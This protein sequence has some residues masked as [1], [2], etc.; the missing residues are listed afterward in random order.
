MLKSS[1]YTES[2][3][4]KAC[5]AAQAQKKPNILKIMH[6]YGV[7]IAILD[8]YIKKGRVDSLI[9]LGNQLIKHLRGIRRKP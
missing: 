8:D 7:L 1:K 3:L 5:E 9:Q 4:C 6:E 2:D